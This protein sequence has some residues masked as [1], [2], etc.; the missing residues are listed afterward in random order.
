MPTC[1]QCQDLL[2]DHVYGLLD[3]QET[4][5]VRAHLSICSNCQSALSKVEAEKKSCWP[6]ACAIREVPEFTLAGNDEQASPAQPATLPISSAGSSKRSM[7]RQTWVRLGRRRHS[8]VCCCGA[9]WVVSSQGGGISGHAVG[10]AC[11]SQASGNSA[12]WR[13]GEVRGDAESRRADL[14]AKNGYLH[15]VGPKTLEPNAKLHVRITARLPEGNLASANFRL[16]LMDV[17]N[18]HAVQVKRA[19]TPMKMAR[20]LPRSTPAMPNRTPS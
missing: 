9:D 17:A 20:C 14:Q 15:V 8:L 3:E 5:A 18:G 1:E 10:H 11:R 4:A 13:A 6:A 19:C 12:C 2:L 7:R 16:K